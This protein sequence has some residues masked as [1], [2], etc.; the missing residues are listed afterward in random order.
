MASVL[1][2]LY[3]IMESIIIQE[4]S[5]SLTITAD[6]RDVWRG[7]ERAAPSRLPHF[8][9]A[10]PNMLTS[11]LRAWAKHFANLAR[12]DASHRGILADAAEFEFGK[13]KRRAC[14]VSEPLLALEVPEVLNNQMYDFVAS[15][16]YW[17]MRRSK[18]ITGRISSRS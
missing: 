10:W 6:R 9:T 8:S 5:S 2:M 1:S 14:I 18:R 12:W 16:L 7:R 4:A 11:A 13:F 17:R 3:C 15:R